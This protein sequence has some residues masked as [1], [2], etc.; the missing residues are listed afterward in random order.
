[1]GTKY[2]D[3]T[4]LKKSETPPQLCYVWVDKVFFFFKSCPMLLKLRIWLLKGWGRCLKV[5]LQTRAPENF[6]SRRWGLSRWYCV[7]KPGSEDPH[8]CERK[9]DILS[10][11]VLVLYR[12]WKPVLFISLALSSSLGQGSN[13]FYLYLA[14]SII[15]FALKLWILWNFKEITVFFPFKYMCWILP[16][17]DQLYFI[18]W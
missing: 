6:R 5:T 16:K 13:N 17:A 14:P 1:M 8:R 18:G 9:F 12:P 4:T 3:S 11:M 15:F 10:C 2:E 7:R